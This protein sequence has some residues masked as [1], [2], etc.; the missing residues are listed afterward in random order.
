MNLIVT[1]NLLYGIEIKLLKIKKGVLYILL[2][3]N[4]KKVINIIDDVE[5]L[6]GVDKLRLVIYYFENLDS[7]T[8]YNVDS[9]I[10]LLKNILGKLD[11]NYNKVITNF[12]KY[13]NLLLILAKN[14]EF[15]EEEKKKFSLELLFNI[16]EYDFKNKNINTEITKGLN[17]Y[18][19][20]IPLI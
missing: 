7:T 13:K 10:Q 16:Y 11:I 2:N 8:N 19:Y 20:A 3:N 4:T 17:V 6:D 1:F 18:D 14:M 5:K 15:T 9:F 12:A